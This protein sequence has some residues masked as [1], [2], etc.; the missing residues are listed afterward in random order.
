M[1][2]KH[3]STR[4]LVPIIFS[5]ACESKFYHQFDPTYSHSI[6]CENG[7]LCF[8]SPEVFISE[9]TCRAW[10]VAESHQRRTLQKSD[11]ASA[12]AHSD[13]FD[14]LIDIVPRDDLEV[15]PY[16]EIGGTE[17]GNGYGEDHVGEDVGD[18]EAVKARK[19]HGEVQVDASGVDSLAED[20]EDLLRE[21]NGLKRHMGNGIL[22][23]SAEIGVPHDVDV[24]LYDQ[25]MDGND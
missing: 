11:V 24:D 7:R 2:K 12:I 14:F 4:L 15:D 20:G 21:S 5:K 8:I 6:C 9:L 18:S 3:R 16:R 23:T 19:G 13:M 25:Y 10:L 1:R 17:D 22:D